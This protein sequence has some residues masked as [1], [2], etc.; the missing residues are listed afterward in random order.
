[1]VRDPVIGF[2]YCI[3]DG[4]DE[5]DEASL[6]MLLNGFKALFSIESKRSAC[7]LSLIVVSREF[8]NF[9]PEILSSFP[10]IRLD[11]D[12]DTEVNNDI[13]RFIKEKVDEL[14]AGGKYPD[15]LSLYVKDIFQKRAQGTF[16]WIG[17]VAKIL[18]KY[19]AIDVEAALELFPPG[20][21]VSD[22]SQSNIS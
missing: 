5:C 10:R 20:L 11:P 6:E 15:S 9:I 21:D 1:M 3:L 19:R 13:N 17:I 8:P 2:A 18:K 16:L 22:V 12:A 14:S 4:L 7:S